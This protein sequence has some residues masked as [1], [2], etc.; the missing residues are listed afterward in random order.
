M[1]FKFLVLL[2]LLAGCVSFPSSPLLPN[3]EDA[4]SAL[5]A[6]EGRLQIFV[7]YIGQGDATLILLP[8]EK[9]LLIDSGPAST[10][11]Q[12]L[13]A[14]LDNLG[15]DRIDGLLITHY[16]WDHL[17][18]VPGLIAGKDQ[19]FE[20]EDDIKIGQA[21]D[22]GTA[23][24]D[25]SPGLP[26][27]RESLA[28]KNIP[29]TAPVLGEDI[30]LDP[31][32][33]IKVLAIDGQVSVFGQ[34][35][36]VDLNLSAYA[37]QENG[38]SIALLIEYGNFRYLTAGD[39]TGGGYLGGFLTPDL[40]TLVAEAV[41]PVDVV[42]I[43]HHGSMSSSNSAYVEAT[44][45]KSIFIQAGIHNAYG[46]PAPDVVKRW[47]EVGAEIFSTQDGQGYSLT[48]DGRNFSIEALDISDTNN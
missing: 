33:H 37:E 45:P 36:G 25:P 12:G 7:P 13:L 4:P 5:S 43:N 6:T 46:H 10:G 18:G 26:S 39:L 22:R 42:H 48:S 35:Q 34:S 11:P 47:N 14:L 17:G 38:A 21:W 32:V 20:T 8:N 3:A 15:I 44:H 30:S 2:T 31:S 23:P 9:T 40:E 29:L 19:K 16:D 24:Y 1:R 27:Y 28:K 41:G